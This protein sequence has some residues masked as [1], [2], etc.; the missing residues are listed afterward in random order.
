MLRRQFNLPHA[1]LLK[2]AIRSFSLTERI[3]FFAFVLIFIGSTF[4]MLIKVNSAFLVSV[5]VSGGELIEG[6]IGSPRF[7]NPL[8]AISDAD[9]DITALVY[10]GLLKA[11]PEGKLVPDLAERFEISEDGK[12]YTFFLRKD[13][14]FHNGTRVTTDD[15]EF[16]VLKAQDPS[17]KSPRRSNW[18]GVTVEKID[19]NEIRF[20][21]KQPYAPFIGNT[22]LGI[23]PRSIWKNATNDE[24]SFSEFNILAI[25]SGPY[26]IKSVGRDSAGIPNEYTLKAFN[27]YALGSPFVTNLRIRFYRNQGE[28]ARALEQGDIESASGLSSNIIKEFEN[29]GIL[30]EEAILPRIFGIF[31][32]Q[33]EVALFTNKEV[34]KA[35]DQSIDKK[36]LVEDIL[37]GYGVAIDGPIP[38]KENPNVQN[39]SSSEERIKV[40][41][42]T[43]EDAGW[44]RNAETGIFEKNTKILQFSLATG[45]A[46]ELKRAAAIIQET[47]EALGADIEVEIY[48][49]GDLNQNVIRPRKYNALLF[50]EIIGRDRDLYP[51][52]HSSQRND[53]GL[54]IALYVNNNVDKLL[55]EARETTDK[56]LQ[57]KKYNEFEKIIK[58]ETPAIFL[59]SPNFLYVV[60]KEIHELSLGQLTI[61]GERF[62]NIHEWYIETSTVWKI[63]NRNK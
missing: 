49:T 38:P 4:F 33:N 30:I 15:V 2:K 47:W 16:T 28:L 10:S 23:L 59:Y 25:G 1:D 31:L 34:R 57:E 24:F 43:L 55:Q 13:A 22:A 53:P 18:E 3:V 11:T 44:K 20:I 36:A 5:P 40:A 42:K 32:N 9:K 37:S 56:D 35:L 51:F 61:S 58:E 46:P 7:I 29:R 39:A 6:I 21:L 26:K 54:N 62:L 52:W 50:G 8:L 41:Q 19:E 63:F 48:E 45:D 60:P 17:L 14:T 27:D 12:T